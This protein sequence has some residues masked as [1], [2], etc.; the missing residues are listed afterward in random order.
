MEAQR[1][2]GFRQFAVDQRP[3]VVFSRSWRPSATP[4]MM[5]QSPDLT[6]SRA[7]RFEQ[8][9]EQILARAVATFKKRSVPESWLTPSQFFHAFRAPRL[10]ET[11]EKRLAWA[12]LSAGWADCRARRPQIRDQ[13]RLWVET[14]SDQLFSLDNLCAILELDAQTTRRAMLARIGLPQ[15]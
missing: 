1:R 5:Q 14:E 15:A 6:R 3:I 9:F 13:L 10:H 12:V 2:N 11:P 7:S 4:A 8:S